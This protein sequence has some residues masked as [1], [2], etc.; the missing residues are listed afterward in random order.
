MW[1]WIPL[2]FDVAREGIDE[3]DVLKVDVEGFE[4]QVFE[5]ATKPL[6][7]GKALTIIFEFCD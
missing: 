4:G 3:V 1:P 6:A 2:G 5:D 7:R